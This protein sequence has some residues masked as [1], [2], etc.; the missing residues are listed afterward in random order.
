[1]N[2]YNLQNW[3]YLVRFLN[4][5]FYGACFIYNIGLYNLLWLC[6]HSIAVFSSKS[7]FITSF[8]VSWIDWIY[9]TFLINIRKMWIIHLQIVGTESSYILKSFDY[10]FVMVSSFH[11][12][13]VFYS[14]VFVFALF[15]LLQYYTWRV[16]CLNII[17]GKYE[18]IR[19]CQISN[20]LKCNIY[21]CVD[22][23]TSNDFDVYK[24]ALRLYFK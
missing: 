1:M 9:C 12:T 21:C 2:L 10:C 24:N 16:S 8:S 3:K 7:N 13:A 4:S 20:Y 6:V 23:L 5:R 19:A 17:C 14:T 11:S 18:Y 22:A 15:E